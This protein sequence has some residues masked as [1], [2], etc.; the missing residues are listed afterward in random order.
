MTCSRSQ[1]QKPLPIPLNNSVFHLIPVAFVPKLNCGGDRRAA[2]QGIS[3]SDWAVLK[4]PTT[5]EPLRGN[6]TPWNA[7]MGGTS[8]KDSMSIHSVQSLTSSQVKRNIRKCVYVR[9]HHSEISPLEWSGI[10]FRFQNNPCKVLNKITNWSPTYFTEV[11][12]KIQG[13]ESLL[14]VPSHSDWATGYR[15]A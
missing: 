5:I 1:G 3:Q 2:R 13:Q 10:D 15:K 8:C 7:N 12:M 6:F 4:P 9:G 11:Q 14:E